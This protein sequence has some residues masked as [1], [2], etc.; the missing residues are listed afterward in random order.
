MCTCL[1]RDKELTVGCTL[2]LLG[3]S[4]K[5]MP[6]VRQVGAKEKAAYT[7]RQCIFN[8]DERCKP[9]SCGTQGRKAGSLV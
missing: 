4:Q 1:L 3:P 8:L 6:D 5:Q 2:D 9:K 7:T